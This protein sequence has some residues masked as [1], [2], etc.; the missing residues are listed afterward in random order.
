MLGKDE[1]LLNSKNFLHELTGSPFGPILPIP[2]FPGGPASPGGPR[3]PCITY[4]F[5][6]G[7]AMLQYLLYS[8]EKVLFE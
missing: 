1:N 2:G 3:G 8:I 7:N 6:C 5:V 4:T